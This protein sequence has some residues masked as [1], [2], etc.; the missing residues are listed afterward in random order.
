MRQ[1]AL[2]ERQVLKLLGH[3][4]NSVFEDIFCDSVSEIVGAKRAA[5]GGELVVEYEP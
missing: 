3:V 2:S 5:H 1:S 4:P